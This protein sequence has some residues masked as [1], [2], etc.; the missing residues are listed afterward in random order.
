MAKKNITAQELLK[1]AN[2]STR[3]NTEYDK[4]ISGLIDCADSGAQVTSVDVSI[5]IADAIKRRLVKNGFC[6][7]TGEI[8]KQ[9]IVRYAVS[10]T[11]RDCAKATTS[12]ICEDLAKT[13]AHYRNNQCVKSVNGKPVDQD[14]KPQPRRLP[15]PPSSTTPAQAGQNGVTVLKNGKPM[16][17]LQTQ[18]PK[19]SAS[20]QQNQPQQNGKKR[21]RRY[22]RGNVFN[23]C[24][25][26]EKCT[27]N[28][29][30]T[31]GDIVVNK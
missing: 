26:F 30:V 18:A 2:A 13:E 12:A 4:I 10:W 31:V 1:R 27:F 19:K 11:E 14:P 21:H 8:R 3:V 20:A 15:T 6:V 9:E 22:N 16:T 25:V 5:D 29:T 24:A 7:S 23:Q 28:V 17:Q